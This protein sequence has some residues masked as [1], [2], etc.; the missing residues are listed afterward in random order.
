MDDRMDSN[1]RLEKKRR[2]SR[3]RRRRRRRRRRKKLEVT[4]GVSD[5]GVMVKEM[6]VDDG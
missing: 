2:R 4:V 6:K 1:A 5:G 3:S